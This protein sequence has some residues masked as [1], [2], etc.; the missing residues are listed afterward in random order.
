MNATR[1]KAG[2]LYS[3]DLGRGT[4]VS[5]WHYASAVSFLKEQGPSLELHSTWPI[6]AEASFFLGAKA[7]DAMLAWLEKGPIRFHELTRDDLPAIRAVLKKYASLEPDF[8]DAALVAL[9]IRQRID[10]IVTVDLR[11][12]SAYRPGKERGFRRLWL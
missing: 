3:R 8:A 12:F 1:A 6:L 4:R 10:A 9:A 2:K 5:N 11:D 7:K